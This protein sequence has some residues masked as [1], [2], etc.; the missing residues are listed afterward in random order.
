M[1]KL[2]QRMRQLV[3]FAIKNGKYFLEILI[4]SKFNNI[5]NIYFEEL[6]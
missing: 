3:N 5:K 1:E 4:P 2:S 6:F